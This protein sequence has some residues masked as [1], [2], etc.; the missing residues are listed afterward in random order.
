MQL[1]GTV[2]AIRRVTVN[3]H[4][5]ENVSLNGI[6]ASV[7][8]STIF[9]TFVDPNTGQGVFSRCR[10]SNSARWGGVRLLAHLC[11]GLREAVPGGESGD[12][13]EARLKTIRRQIKSAVTGEQES[14]TSPYFWAPFVL[15]GG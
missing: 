10:H 7:D 11:L 9:A 13:R 4:T 3:G 1:N 5:L 12:R 15:I 6:A 14:L 8:A 2:I